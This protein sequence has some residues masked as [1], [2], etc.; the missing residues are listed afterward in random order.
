M[1]VVIGGEEEAVL[2][3]PTLRTLDGEIALRLL[4]RS[5]SAVHGCVPFVFPA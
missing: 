1:G 2:T 3:K 4:A 5:L